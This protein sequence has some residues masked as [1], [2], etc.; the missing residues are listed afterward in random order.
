MKPAP[1]YVGLLKAAELLG[2]THQAVTEFQVVT[3]KRLPRIKAGRSPI[4]FYYRK[5]MAEVAKEGI[6]EHKTD[7][8]SMK[9][10]GPELTALD[11]VRYPRAAAGLDHIVTVL[12]DLGGRLDANKL[13]ALSASFERAVLQRMGYL[14][15]LA[16]HGQKAYGVNERLMQQPP[17]PWV[18]LEPALASDPD[19]APDPIERDPRWNVIVRRIPEPD[20]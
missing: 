17:L 19:F 20:E 18:E 14:L 11:L 7:T 15:T 12:A 1:Y 6:Q 10:S 8:G 16:G 13:A 2:A 3:N 5:N 9:I 4:A